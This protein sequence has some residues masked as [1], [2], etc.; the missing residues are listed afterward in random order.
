MKL[1]AT[2]WK[3][4]VSNLER[5]GEPTDEKAKALRLMRRMTRSPG[6]WATDEEWEEFQRSQRR[7]K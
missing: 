7:N 1:T 2:D 3:T 6:D 5:V 4:A